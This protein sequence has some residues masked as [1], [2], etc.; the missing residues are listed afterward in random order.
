M[1]K[2]NYQMNPNIQ[3][4]NDN[5]IGIDPIQKQTINHQSRKIK[6]LLR[7]EQVLVVVYV[8]ISP[9]EIHQQHLHIV[10]FQVQYLM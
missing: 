7:F 4:Q 1:M 9:F 8:I 5:K 2:Q 10:F 6:Y 3:V